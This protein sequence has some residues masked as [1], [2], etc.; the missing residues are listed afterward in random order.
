[1]E[2]FR[3]R[4]WMN[5]LPEH[6]DY[7]FTQIL[8]ISEKSSIAGNVEELEKLEEQDEARVNHLKGSFVLCFVLML[9]DDAVF[10]D[11]ELSKKEFVPGALQGQ[12]E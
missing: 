3:D 10:K 5:L 7:Q 11:L 1:M 2:Q 6:L 8:F 9:G 12:I 4:R